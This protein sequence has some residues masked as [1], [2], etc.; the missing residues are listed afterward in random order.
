MWLCACMPCMEQVASSSSQCR[1][2]GHG[3]AHVKHPP[4]HIVVLTPASPA[5]PGGATLLLVTL[6]S[7]STS[8][9]STR[10]EPAAPVWVR[11]R[12][13]LSGGYSVRTQL[14]PSAAAAAWLVCCCRVCRVRRP[15]LWTDFSPPLLCLGRLGSSSG[16]QQYQQICA[17]A[18]ACSG[19][20][21]RV[22]ATPFC[23]EPT[24]TQVAC[25]QAPSAMPLFWGVAG[26]RLR[27]AGDANPSGL[28]PGCTANYAVMM[29][30][31][32]Q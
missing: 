20:R 18:L 6:R 21:V 29:A 24:W 28:S 8:R 22:C 12:S 13:S 17:K 30:V 25:S 4:L 32:M 14:G 2:H 26:E 15:C 19:F 16:E 27:C 11:G 3:C 31:T 10:F 9:T 7:S 23:G 5:A 1:R